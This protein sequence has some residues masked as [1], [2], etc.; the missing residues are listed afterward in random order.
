MVD[1]KKLN[2]FHLE[3][4]FKITCK[5]SDTKWDCSFEELKVLPVAI[6]PHLLA[7]HKVRETPHC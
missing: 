7:S 5:Y 2:A 1:E 3:D 4:T 6:C